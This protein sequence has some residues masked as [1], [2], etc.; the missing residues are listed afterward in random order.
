MFSWGFVDVVWNIIVSPDL[1]YI[2]VFYTKSFYVW[3]YKSL[4]QR[5]NK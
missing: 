5:F 1:S 3:I 4:R 2:C